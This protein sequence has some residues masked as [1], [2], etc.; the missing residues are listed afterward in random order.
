MTRQAPRL[1]HL[2]ALF[3]RQQ[4][5]IAVTWAEMA[6][7]LPGTQYAEHSFAELRS[8]LSR[9]VVAAVETLSTGSYEP[10]EA[11]L[12][13]L[14]RTRS[15]MNFDISEVTEALLLLKEAALP[16]IQRA[17]PAGSPKIDEAIAALETY[18]RFAVGRL[19]HLYAEAIE[20]ELKESEERFRALAE[21]TY[22]W[23][24]W[25]SPDGEYVYVSPSCERITGY[26]SEEFTENPELLEAIVH[27]DDREA[28]AN[29]LREEPIEGSVVHPLEFRVMTR[30]GEER[31]LE[32]VCQP[33]YSSN[34]NYLGRRGSN[35]DITG[36]RRA[37]QALEEE[38]KERA[39][40]AERS[41]LARE[42]HDS[43]T[44]ALYSVTLYA[45]ATRLAFSAEKQ[46]VAMENLRELHN[47]AR[48]A[49]LDMRMLIFE[50]HPPVLEEE[51]LIA[52]LQARLAAVE[53][54]ARLQTEI[55]VEGERRLPLAM[56][57]EFF[58][59]AL[60]AL[61]NVIKH[62]KAQQVTVNL[63][64][65]GKGVCL[66]IVD[67]GVGFDP[68]AARQGGGMGLA[69]IEQRVQRIQGTWAI[70]SSP[71]EGTMLRVTAPDMGIESTE[72]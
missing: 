37:E 24:Y 41:R 6:Y 60:E 38:V 49:M 13:D 64:F 4:A 50:L 53:S 28:V 10:T 58:R 56:E 54:R 44:Q 59:I 16:F 69:G 29:H 65:E 36:R 21:F 57:E 22:D 32:H 30:C 19:G 25:L 3:S 52:A 67:D 43:V 55:R 62:A 11:H 8:C 51:G 34:G 12:Q 26:C 9:G 42:L 23:E 66:E 40:A 35:R 70:E 68:A 39:I 31:W 15:Q 5:E 45:E 46:A 27:P 17:Y 72:S 61:N 2:A 20:K 33:V 1:P 7:N 18:L 71:G 47:I 63:K 48:E 14:S